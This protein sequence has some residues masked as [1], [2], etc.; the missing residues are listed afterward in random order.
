M[1]LPA[2]EHLQLLRDG[3]ARWSLNDAPLSLPEAAHVDLN[4]MK[5]RY[6]DWGG[7]AG[8]K[9]IV[10]LHGG[11]LTAHAWDLV[12]LGLRTSWRCIALDARG[13][14][15]SDWS[16]AH[17]YRISSQRSDVLTFLD[18]LGLDQVALVGHSMG[19]FTAI[20]LAAHAPLR[21]AAL[22]LVD[23]GPEPREEGT[24]QIRG[25][26]SQASDFASIDEAVQQVLAFTPAR[27]PASLRRSLQ[28]ALRE[29]VDGR[30]RWKYDP[31]RYAQ[32]RTE[33]FARERMALWDDL[34]AIHCP[35][36]VIRGEKSR[37]FWQQDAERVAATLS[38]ARWVLAAGAG[39]NVH[40]E[41]PRVI[42]DSV[43]ELLV[44][45]GFQ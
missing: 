33:A 1:S 37:V 27:N 18:A 8:L 7:A 25:L 21:V 15:D 19:G 45:A 14:G 5:F 32:L 2:S 9:T 22:T 39:H 4:G 10:L 3:A 20:S 17:D 36:Q 6:L 26:V 35:A 43:T 40:S 11:G 28:I 16:S 12:C 44:R 31:A 41:N 42:I 30:W 29:G 23:I 24:R 13:H 34:R 38:D